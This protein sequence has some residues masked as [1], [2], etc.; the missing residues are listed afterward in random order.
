MPPRIFGVVF[1]VQSSRPGSTRSGD[2]ARKKSLPARRPE[3]C[4]R[5]GSSTS[6]VVPGQVV[7]SSTTTWPGWSTAA[8]PRVA[9]STIERSGSRW[10]ESGVGSA[11]R[12]ASASFMSA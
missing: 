1:V 11:I 2:I 7:D 6:R 4:S 5:I 9:D 12:I 3:P 10:R 8:I